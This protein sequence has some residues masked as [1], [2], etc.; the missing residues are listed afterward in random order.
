VVVLKIF[1]FI[2]WWC[3][4]E[5]ILLPG[6]EILLPRGV[7]D[8]INGRKRGERKPP[9]RPIRPSKIGGRALDS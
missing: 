3:C 1:S 9:L 8:E 5:K 7:E 4:N 2:T 6:K